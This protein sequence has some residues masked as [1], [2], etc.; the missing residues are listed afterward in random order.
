MPD[1]R[2]LP[3]SVSPPGTPTTGSEP[4]TEREDS[5]GTLGP[6]H[7]LAVALEDV[8]FH[9]ADTRPGWQGQILQAVRNARAALAALTQERDELK[10]QV[11]GLSADV[12]RLEAERGKRWAEAEAIERE[13]LDL[14]EQYRQELA[15]TTQ[16]VVEERARAEAA[17]V[18]VK[19]LEQQT[20]SGLQQAE[21][22]REVFTVSWGD[23]RSSCSATYTLSGLTRQHES[24]TSFLRWLLLDLKRDGCNS[25]TV[26]L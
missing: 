8:E 14:A 10:S 15:W 5:R 24:G 6:A 16:G 12:T 2:P 1:Q 17:E 25:V 3:S 18:R 11:V 22:P 7:D 4:R 20:G 9:T 19:E 13:A 23:D 21:D 26:S